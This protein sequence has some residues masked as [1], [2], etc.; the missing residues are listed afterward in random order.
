MLGRDNSIVTD[1][2]GGQLLNRTTCTHCNYES[3]AFD[4][5]WDLSLSFTRGLSMLDKCDLPRMIEHFLKEEILDDLFHCVRCKKDRKFKKGFVI[6]RLPKVLV[7]HLKRFH[8]G[9]YRKEKI[10]HDVRFPVKNLD[11]SEFV[12]E[13]KDI[14]VKDAKYSLF[15][16]VNH[17]G[18]LNGGH[19]TAD[20]MNPYDKKWYT[21][22]DSMVRE[23]HVVSDKDTEIEG[24]SPYILFYI[25]NS[26][27]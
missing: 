20:C 9:K 16:I 15:S 19:Y 13:S 12:K 27:V 26:C 22:N 23:S 17:S 6:W 5:Y 18:S 7:I 4:N 1:L 8:Y 10:T 14:S 2:F 11:L 25:K 3:I 24:E 21:F